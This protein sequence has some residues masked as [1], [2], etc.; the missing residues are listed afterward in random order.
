M[1]EICCLCSQINKDASGDLL[2][3]VIGDGLGASDRFIREWTD[4]VVFPSIGA[5]TTGHVLLCPKLHVRSMAAL[6]CS[7]TA[8][9]DSAT[10]VVRTLLADVF[11]L[12]VHAFEHGNGDGGTHIV[13][14]VEHAHLHLLPADV[15]IDAHLAP[16]RWTKVLGSL[17][18]I[19]RG[20]EYLFYQEPSG[21]KW[22]TTCDGASF[23]S[24]Y[25]RRAFADALG[26]A[27]RWNWRDDPARLV[28]SQT[29]YS[30]TG[31]TVAT[32]A[33]DEVLSS[34]EWGSR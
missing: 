8:P 24:Q 23:P 1:N 25:M 22:V 16:Y 20:R 28:T 11:G 17:T 27:G 10:A 14:T 31:R 9:F 4:F 21:A 2:G 18:D 26:V 33:A 6:P 3:A 13:C 5:L 29:L 7:L 15:S 19:T 32:K 34:P 30:L 12:Q